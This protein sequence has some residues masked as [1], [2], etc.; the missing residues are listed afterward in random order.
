MP[1]G[2]FY[3]NCLDQVISDRRDSL[4]DFIITVFIGISVF[5]ADSVDPDQ[6]PRSVASDPGQH[7]LLMSLLWDAGHKWVN[8]SFCFHFFIL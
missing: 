8:L 4:L 3:L 6:T 2:L 7:C 5:N 1:N